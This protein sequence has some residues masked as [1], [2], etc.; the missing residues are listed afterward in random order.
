MIFN[1][2]IPWNYVYIFQ[3]NIFLS[4]LFPFFLPRS[5]TKHNLK[6]QWAS[7]PSRGTTPLPFW[8]IPVNTVSAL[9]Q[10]IK[11]WFSSRY[12]LLYFLLPQ[13]V[14][15]FHGIS[16]IPQPLGARIELVV[17]VEV[18]WREII[19]SPWPKLLCIALVCSDWN[20]QYDGL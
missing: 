17:Q 16:S 15:S 11:N 9:S 20:Y 10:N 14:C 2:M 19:L 8:S 5:Y 12:I 3:H 13:T 7:L 6:K 1:S 4:F 18:G